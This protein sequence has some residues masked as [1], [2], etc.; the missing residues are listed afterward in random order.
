MAPE[1]RH[2]PRP[3]RGSAD[4]GRA[5]HGREGG[6]RGL[7]A[8]APARRGALAPW[9]RLPPGVDGAGGRGRPGTLRLVRGPGPA[10]SRR[11]PPA[12]NE[13]AP[14]RLRG[15]GPR[16]RVASPGRARGPVGPRGRPPRGPP[17]AS[18]ATAPRPARGGSGRSAGDSGL[19]ALLTPVED[20]EPQDRQKG[21]RRCGRWA[22][23]LCPPSVDRDASRPPAPVA[24]APVQDHD[25]AGSRPLA[26]PEKLVE[27]CLVRGQDDDRL[28]GRRRVGHR[29]HCRGRLPCG[30]SSPEGLALAWRA[31]PGL[32][33][34]RAGTRLRV[35]TKGMSGNFLFYRRFRSTS[36]SAARP[37]GWAQ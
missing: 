34:E 6:R 30:P 33:G 24:S 23:S 20:H 28:G 8:P 31:R 15:A 22:A 21:E 7:Y 17:S 2:R 4:R 26:I 13:P 32:R 18:M 29:A 36:V 12:R 37:G 10:A 25:G 16:G 9:R 27:G 3:A 1:L 11:S 14:G 35:G 5:R 19:P